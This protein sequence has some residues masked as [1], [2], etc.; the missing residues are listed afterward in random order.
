MPM[1]IEVIMRP[2]LPP[3]YNSV[4]PFMNA[5]Y[6]KPNPGTEVLRRGERLIA[7]GRPLGCDILWE[8]DVTVT[9]RDGTKLY[10]DVFRPKEPTGRVPAILSWSPYG[11]GV[12]QG[13]PPGVPTEWVSG[14]QKF[15]GPDPAYW[16]AHG[17]AVVNV[18][19]RGAYDSEGDI[20]FWGPV[21]ARDG[22]DVVEWVAA[23]P[24]CNGR[25]GMS[26]NSWLAIAQWF[27]AAEN[28]PSLKAIAPWEGLTDLY[29]HDVVR[30]GI[31]NTG[32]CEMVIRSLK[33]RNNVEDIPR[34]VDRYPFMNPYW[35]SKIPKVER[36]SVP[37]YVV[38]SW[39]NDIHTLGTLEGFR[40]LG[41][42]EKW[43]RVHNTHEWHDYYSP[44]NLEELRAFFDHYLKGEDNGWQETPRV[45]ISVLDPSGR[46]VVN[47]EEASWP[48]PVR[49]RRLY[50]DG[51]GMALRD[52]PP[53]EGATVA[54]KADD[55]RGKAVFEYE[56]PDDV[57]VVGYISL[58]LYVEVKGAEDGDLFVLLE[59]ADPRGEP[60]AMAAGPF[61]YHGPH[62]RLRI[63][64]RELD[65]ELSTPWL[66]VPSHRKALPLREGEVV[67]CDIC[68]WPTGMR[69]RKGEK[70]R[71]TVSGFNPVPFHLPDVPGPQLVNRGLHVIH[72]GG[73]YQSYLSLPV[74]T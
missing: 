6:R 8:R 12:P 49:Y 25:V 61:T 35:E 18:D 30:G 42:P 65:P 41:S 71:L 54:Y 37:A 62:G 52:L 23:R 68:L 72:T 11:K 9:L 58:R 59:K 20:H 27:I 5:P 43:L 47:R 44:Q 19:T 70:M 66:P 36:I 55:G 4:I 29:R 2:A 60:L 53:A 73:E 32:F 51:Q 13:P 39:S 67:P 28:P 34:M 7:G 45:R 33:G 22:Y 31:P 17:Y 26:G 3:E 63:S 15:E 10:V 24:W 38:A 14:L 69:W 64:H 57:E 56:V 16:C 21:D 1:E 74:K 46:D 48:V 40:R 50:L